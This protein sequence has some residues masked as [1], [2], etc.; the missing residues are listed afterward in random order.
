MLRFVLQR[1]QE[2]LASCPLC[3]CCCWEGG[4][5]PCCADWGPEGLPA[6]T[7]GPGGPPGLGAGLGGCCWG[8]VVS[9]IR[10]LAWLRRDAP[11]PNNFPKVCSGG[12]GCR[13]GELPALRVWSWRGCWGWWAG[14]LRDKSGWDG[15]LAIPGRG[16]APGGSL[17][18]CWPAPAGPVCLVG[19]GTGW[20]CN[21]GCVWGG[22]CVWG[23]G[24]AEA[25]GLGSGLV[26]WEG[27]WICCW[28]LERG[29]VISIPSALCIWQF[30]HNHSWTWKRK[31]NKAMAISYSILFSQW[32]T[33][34]T[35]I[36]IHWIISFLQ[37]LKEGC[38]FI[39]LATEWFY[40]GATNW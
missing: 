21:G 11:K 38:I 36:E 32:G 14:E 1:G 24:W 40:H 29:V 10:V 2:A 22:V 18:C 19:P 37:L 12:G 17:A 23:V 39:L 31:K 34:D 35:K 20:A 33:L 13:E 8:W 7:P 5:G 6:P 9:D 15:A 28:L 30:R 25:L 4:R 27:E 3:C 26:A 16:T